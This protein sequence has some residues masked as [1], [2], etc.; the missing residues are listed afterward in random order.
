M[1]GKVPLHGR[2]NNQEQ[3]TQGAAEGV[4]ARKGMEQEGHGVGVGGDG[5]IRENG[6]A[7]GNVDG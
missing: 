7:C 6:L 4:E 2:A 1:V 5:R 3:V